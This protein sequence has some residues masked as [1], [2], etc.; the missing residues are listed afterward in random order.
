M[1][2]VITGG[3]G[4]I[5]SHIAELALAEGHSVL[6]VDDLSTG[7]RENVPEGAELAEVD[8]RDRGA[9]DEALRRFEP[10]VVSHQAAQASVVVSL[11]DPLLDAAINLTG[12]LNVIE[13]A[14]AVGARK[15]VFASTGGAIYGEIPEPERAKVG[16]PPLPIS[17]YA[18]SKLAVEHYLHAY[19]LN[20][21]LEPVVLRY[22]NVYGP[23][24]DPHGEAGVVAIFGA[25]LLAGEAVKVF[26]RRTPGDGGCVR[27]YVYVSD[28]ARANLLAVTGAVEASVVNVCTGRATT[29]AELLSGLETLLERSARVEQCGQRPGDVERSVLD[30]DDAVAAFGPST[31][32]DEGLAATAAWFR[33]RDGAA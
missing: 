18:C 2:V 23:R 26:A 24:Q 21:G 10:D 8:I 29:T 14:L 17:P 30:A 3:A 22:A 27:D 16:R 9:L 13:A 20:R 25:R 28:V 12:S 33:G 31:S 1:R 11:R 6:C 5:G 15:L 32:L 19:R 4:F 7:R